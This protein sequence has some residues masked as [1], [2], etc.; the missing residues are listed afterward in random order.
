[1]RGVSE[2]A[3]R[4]GIIGRAFRRWQTRLVGKL[5][6]WAF[7]VVVA[8]LAL[9]W[10][11]RHPRV[12]LPL[13][14]AGA[15]AYVWHRWGWPPFAVL[16][17]LALATLAL[18]RVREVAHVRARRAAF[19]AAGL[20]V[21]PLRWQV[22]PRRPVDP[23]DLSALHLGRRDNGDPVPF[24]LWRPGRG[25]T[26]LLVAGVTGAGKGSAV[27]S[28]LSEVGPAIRDGL[29]SVWGIDP[30]G[31]AELGGGEPLF[32]RFVCGGSTTGVPWQTAIADL[33]DEAVAGMQARLASMRDPQRPGGPV[34][35]H[36]PTEAEPLILIVVD[37]VSAIT[38]YAPPAIRTR[39]DNSLSLLLSQGRAA[40]VSVVLCT[41]DPRV[42]TL[43]FRALIPERIAL[44]TA[45]PAADLILGPGMRARGALTERI[46][47]RLPGVGYLLDE[48]S[49]DPVR[50]RLPYVSDAQV[51]DLAA[52]YR[53]RPPVA[54][55]PYRT[56]ATRVAA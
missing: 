45:D 2:D 55:E 20:V 29:V 38:A 16:A 23:V 56:P 30:K 1:V 7:P 39:I 14:A 17:A 50:F 41:Q 24:A 51:V 6:G 5:L 31:G 15:A 54:E 26:H 10:L 43:R 32:D 52:R 12:A 46:D 53:R 36:T 4:P 8:A 42:E 21:D 19:R 28:L 37:E 47:R 27:W 49:A 34:R 40:A 9:L 25:S 13:A 3:D 44:R 18:P 33:L 11:T 22:R 35:W 48:R